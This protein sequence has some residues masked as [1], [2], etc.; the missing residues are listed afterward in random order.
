VLVPALLVG[1][2]RI[3]KLGIWSVPPSSSPNGRLGFHEDHEAYASIGCF[4][5]HRLIDATSDS[6]FLQNSQARKD[7]V[8]KA[9]LGGIATTLLDEGVSH[10]LHTHLH[11]HS[12]IHTRARDI[13]QLPCTGYRE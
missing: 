9:V 13:E 12:H 4:L 2:V 8:P 5:C 10:V 3:V 6:T 7:D 11:T 1:Q